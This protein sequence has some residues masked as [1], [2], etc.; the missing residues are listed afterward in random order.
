MMSAFEGSAARSFDRHWRSGPRAAAATAH[1]GRW[2][3]VQDADSPAVA[4]QRKVQASIVGNPFPPLPVHPAD[5][6][7]RAVSRG[8]GYASF[9]AGVALVGWLVL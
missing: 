7:L 3:P 5:Q 8:A 2:A 6:V 9:A 4:L 1:E